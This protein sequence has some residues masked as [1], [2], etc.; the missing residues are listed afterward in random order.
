MTIDE[1]P[2]DPLWPF[3]DEINLIRSLLG[4]AEGP[5][6]NPGIRLSRCLRFIV[7]EY[8]LDAQRD[9]AEPPTL[10]D[11]LN[12]VE[13]LS[14]TTPTAEVL[15]NA[16]L[17][18]DWS[19]GVEVDGCARLYGRV[20][21]H[22]RLSDGARIFTSPYLRLDPQ[23]SWARSWSRFYR[24][25]TY[26]RSFMGELILDEVLDPQTRSIEIPTR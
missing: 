11:I 2:F 4:A 7:N 23:N 12:K 21:N 3:Q 20:A 16:P 25:G 6:G 15:A 19:P 10:L 13:G 18:E 5:D 17:L 1:Q 22:P 26:N 24:L 9:R 8:R 14:Q